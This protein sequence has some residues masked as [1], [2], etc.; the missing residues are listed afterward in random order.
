[1]LPVEDDVV[2]EGLRHMAAP[3]EGEARKRV[4]QRE[5]VAWT[6]ILLSKFDTWWNGL[7]EDSP[8]RQEDYNC[9]FR[10]ISAYRS[11]PIEGIRATLEKVHEQ[12]LVYLNRLVAR[13]VVSQY[14]WSWNS[15]DALDT[16][17][18]EAESALK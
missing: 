11:V 14:W 7:A 4:W 16:L 1:M 5:L 2:R 3:F 13:G 17:V 8:F 15:L 18:D 12:F 9:L 6:R 10:A